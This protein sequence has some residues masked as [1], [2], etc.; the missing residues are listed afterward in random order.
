MADDMRAAVRRFQEALARRDRVAVNDTAATLIALHAPLGRQW[1]SVAAALKWNGECGLSLSAI[2]EMIDN[3]N[4]HSTS[5]YARANLLYASSRM[6]EALKEL[7][8]LVAEGQGPRTVAD[9]VSHLNFRASL[10]LLMGGTDEARECLERAIELDPRS[11]QA[12]LSFTEIADFRERDAGLGTVLERSWPQGATLPT[13]HSKLAH[14]VGRMRHQIRDYAG[15]FEAFSEGARLFEPNPGDKSSE[16]RDDLVGHATSWTPELIAEVA[17]RI[18]VPHD[19]VI[20]VSGLPRSGTTL[21]EQIL[22]SHPDVRTGEEFGFVRILGQDIGGVDAASFTAWLDRGGDPNALVELY[23]HL[24]DERIGPEGRFVDK[25][26]EA[27]KYI[28]LLLALFPRAPVFWLQRDRIDNGWSAFR[29]Y[30]A[31]GA[32]WSWDLQAIGRRLAQEDQMVAHWS[33]SGQPQL[34]FVDY[35]ALVRNPEPHIRQIADAAGLVLD[36]AMLRPHETERTVS[37]ASVSQVREPI[38]LKGLGAAGPY[39]EWLSPMIDAY[40]QASVTAGSSGKE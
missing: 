18:T 21:V 33:R 36:E 39:R 23:L 11:G 1:Q 8:A 37:T 30:F 22:V 38:N 32:S 34:H 12:W 20:F 3:L 31:R 19:R 28:G 9:H 6:G 35:E 40:A 17:A 26:V 2:D 10:F 24:A 7:D 16:I 15:A 5:R 4:G 27:G 25:T 14:A 13:E 29:T